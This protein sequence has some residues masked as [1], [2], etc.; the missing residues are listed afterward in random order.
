MNIR[1][2]YLFMFSLI[3]VFFTGK[4]TAQDTLITQYGD[5]L[6]GK[7]E[8]IT[9]SKIYFKTAYRTTAVDIKLEEVASLRSPEGFL[10]NDVLNQNWRGQLILDST[11]V[12]LIGIQTKDSLYFFD[13]KDI[14]EITK[15]EKKRFKDRFRLGIDLGFA[16]AKSEN[17][18]SL[19]AGLHSRYRTR[20]WDTSLDYQDYAS[21]IGETLVS[22]TSLDY[23]LAYIFKREWFVNGKASLFSSTEQS[24][25]LRR[26]FSAGLGKNLIHR[27]DKILSLMGGVVSNRERFSFRSDEF[28]SLE[29]IF[30]SHLSGKFWDKVNLNLDWAVFP[31]FSESGRVRNTFDSSLSY[32]FLNHFNIGIHYVLNTDNRPPIETENR[33]FILVI[34]FGWTFQKR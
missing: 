5:L 19:S 25:D 22:R 32:L 14:Y 16:R 34:K 7:V 4:A 33:D 23:N 9:S 11:Q 8:R 2:V 26:V 17:A 30:S 6:L 1:M 13:Q 12:N 31:S 3:L 28:S 29:G 27:E 24:L 18:L 20:R 21:V 15:D 10:V